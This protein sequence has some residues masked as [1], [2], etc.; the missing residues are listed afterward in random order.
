VTVFASAGDLG[1]QTGKWG[2]DLAAIFAR[3]KKIH[4]YKA[5]RLRGATEEGAA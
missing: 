5:G 4:R 1:V 3:S 2:P